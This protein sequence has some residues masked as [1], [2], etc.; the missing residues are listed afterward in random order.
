MRRL[1]ISLLL[2]LCDVTKYLLYWPL[3][4]LGRK[5]LID[6][7]FNPEIRSMSYEYFIYFGFFIFNDSNVRK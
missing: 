4:L 3:T 5:C 6:L 2:H 1:L 7:S